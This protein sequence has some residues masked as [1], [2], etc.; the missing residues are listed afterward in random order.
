V[1]IKPEMDAMNSALRSKDI[2][3]GVFVPVSHLLKAELKK[4]VQAA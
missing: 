2:T 1:N 3:K 4:A